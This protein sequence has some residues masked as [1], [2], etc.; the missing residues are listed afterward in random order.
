RALLGTLLVFLALLFSAVPGSAQVSPEIVYTKN[1]AFWI[2]F[3]PVSGQN[4]LR[5]VQL[6]YSIDQGRSW[7]QFG[8][9]RPEQRGFDFRA[10]RDGIYWFT[11][12][13]VDTDGRLFP[14]VL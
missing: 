14:P 13:T 8:S 2:P 9:V 11:V 1:T 12:R 5:Q 10:D 7:R 4:S 3:E 6:H